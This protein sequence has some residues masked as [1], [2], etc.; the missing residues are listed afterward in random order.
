MKS[1]SNHMGRAL[2]QKSIPQAKLGSIGAPA[3]TS[4]GGK[5]LDKAHLRAPGTTACGK[6]L[7]C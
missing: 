1:G 4:V 3:K 7:A 2:G 6:R 5:K